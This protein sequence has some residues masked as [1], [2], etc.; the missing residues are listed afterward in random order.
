MPGVIM[1]LP[2]CL[3]PVCLQVDATYTPEIPLEN[4]HVIWPDTSVQFLTHRRG[5]CLPHTRPCTGHWPEKDTWGMRL[6]PKTHAMMGGGG[7]V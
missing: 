2:K 3:T 6:A 4:L 1:F 7:A 5:T